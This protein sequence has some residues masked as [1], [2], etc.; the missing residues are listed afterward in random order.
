MS[1]EYFKT[2]GINFSTLA[3][4]QVC[5]DCVRMDRRPTS[6]FENGKAFELVF[7]DMVQGSNLFAERYF[8]AAV[9]GGIPD[10]V[11]CA[12][13]ANQELSECYTLNKDG[14]RSKTATRTHEW[15][16][17]CLANPGKI[18]VS[19]GEFDMFCR[20]AENLL[21]AELLGATVREVLAGAQFQVPVYW[22]DKK[23]L[24]DIETEWNGCRY[25]FDLKAM[26]NLSMFRGGFFKRYWIQ[27]VHYTEGLHACRPFEKLHPA[28][29]FLVATKE[30]P[31]VA[32][33]FLMDPDRRPAM[34][35]RYQNLCDEYQQWRDA[36]RPSR[37]WRPLE[38]L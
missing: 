21:N 19:Q 8:V 28:M 7:Q 23:A 15:L 26:A 24:F 2:P 38:Y 9:D 6:Y 17:A 4:F 29:I 30:A 16:D 18:P 33:P 3:D 22:Q 11:V 20:M 14:S 37:G 12:L 1:E 31:F 35:E 27:D 34:I 10:K 32:Q 13:E 36:G 5:P 25:I